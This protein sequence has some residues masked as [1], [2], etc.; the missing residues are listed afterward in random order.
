MSAAS[1]QQMASASQANALADIIDRLDYRRVG[2]EEFDDPVFR[3][4]YEAYR[5]E[6][7]I[8]FNSAG[9]LFDEFDAQPNAYCYGVY[10][11]DELVSSLR[12]HHLTPECRMSPS[13]SVF[14]DWLD[15]LLDEGK[16]FIDPSRFTTDLDASLAYPA[17]PFLTL[18]LAVMATK[19]FNTSHGIHSVRPEHG[20]FYK[21]IWG[22]KPF[23][24]PRYYHG[25]S[26]PM[27]LW[28]TESQQVYER[29]LRRFPLF[30][31]TAEE[32]ERLFGR[33][34]K[35]ALSVPAKARPAM[36]GHN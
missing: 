17:L 32:R 12:I 30:A 36:A 10:I 20:A 7:F 23:A 25:L 21:R 15:P 6:E 35:L 3:L 16:S 4:R 31:S 34:Q 1:G 8:P 24:P 22:A 29:T 9:T 11:D 2:P 14:T 33:N 26:F 13:Y 27:E 28:I 5:R 18:R 19:Y